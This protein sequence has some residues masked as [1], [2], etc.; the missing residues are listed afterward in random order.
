MT[1]R[2][3]LEEAVKSARAALQAAESALYRF[4]TAIE[5]NVFESVEKARSV[6]EDRLY[7]EASDDCEGSYNFGS[8]EYRQE[9]LVDGKGYVAI[10]EV[11]YNRHDKTYYYVDGTEFRVEEL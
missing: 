11:E 5:N 7:Q 9:F 3:E 6:L 1:T 2:A 4:D 10:L 8:N